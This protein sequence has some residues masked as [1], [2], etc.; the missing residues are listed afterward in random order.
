MIDVICHSSFHK[1]RMISL[2]FFVIY[3]MVFQTE[4][5]LAVKLND[6]DFHA[7]YLLVMKLL[8]IRTKWLVACLCLFGLDC[9]FWFKNFYFV[10]FLEIINR[11]NTSTCRLFLL[12]LILLF[13]VSWSLM[14]F[15]PSR[16]LL[17]WTFALYLEFLHVINISLILFTVSQVFKQV[18]FWRPQDL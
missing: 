17:M 1:L 3:I 4:N 6:L 18:D 16:S 9:V 8:N 13:L 5:Y 14:V 7:C 15:N 12:I 2:S 11:K 10:W